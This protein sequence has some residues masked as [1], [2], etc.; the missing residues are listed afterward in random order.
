MNVSATSSLGSIANLQNL[1]SV[2][3]PGASDQDGDGD[4]SSGNIGSARPHRGGRME[5]A[6]MQA[7]QSMGLTM[8]PGPPPSASANTTSDASSN[9]S[10]SDSSTQKTGDTSA[11]TWASSCMQCSKR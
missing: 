6:M 1:S 9:N 8:P 4:G 7:L 10:S 3:A 2:Q 11:R 5:Q